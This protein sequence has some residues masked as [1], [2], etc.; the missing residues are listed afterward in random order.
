[1]KHIMGSYSWLNI[2]TSGIAF[3]PDREAVRQE[4]QQHIEDKA[5][6]LARIFP[7]MEE[8]EV[9]ERALQEMGDAWELKQKLAHIHRP[10]MGYLWRC[11]QA[12]IWGVLVLILITLLDVG[13]YQTYSNW[14]YDMIM[15]REPYTVGQALYGRGSPDWEGEQLAVYNVDARARL[16]GSTIS[17]TRAA[18]WR[19]PEGE[20][21]YFRLCVTWDRPWE[22]NPMTVNHFWVEDDLGNTYQMNH[23]RSFCYRG[24]RVLQDWGLEGVS[25]EAR[26]LY[27]HYGLRD[28]LDL[29]VDLTE[30]VEP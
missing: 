22:G 27:I 9:H 3:G 7:D 15:L 6:D 13:I 12:L 10:W 24:N 20:C 11:T 8:R 5:M 19:E 2:A 21:V 17:V 1:M 18:R 4:L 16:G 25:P 29:V 30:E 23:A 26:I 14:W 28:G